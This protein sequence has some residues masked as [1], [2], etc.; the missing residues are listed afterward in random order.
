MQVPEVSNTET[1]RRQQKYIQ[2]YISIQK[3]IEAYR[4]VQKQQICIIEDVA[5]SAEDNCVWQW[6]LLNNLTAVFC[7]L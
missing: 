3:P 6:L 7:Q 2:V 1:Y 4:S 5:V